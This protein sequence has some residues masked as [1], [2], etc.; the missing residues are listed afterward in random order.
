M[1]K[2]FWNFIH[3]AVAHPLMAFTP[4]PY[5]WMWKFHDFTAERME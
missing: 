1:K 4:N 2:W 3:N 5:K